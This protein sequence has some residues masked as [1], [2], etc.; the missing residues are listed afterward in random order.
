MKP[1]ILIGIL[2][3]LSIQ[4]QGQYYITSFKKDVAPM[5]LGLG[6]TGIGIILNANADAADLEEINLLNIDDLNFLDRG[7]V[8]SYSSTAHT[9]SDLILY[10]SATLP[11]IT[12]FSNKRKANSGAIALMAIETALINN[13]I[14]TIV[15]S[16]VQRYRPFNYNPR[17][18]DATK[19][20]SSSRKSFISGHVSTTASFAFL[21]ARIITDLHPGMKR[22][23]LVWITAACLPTV[24]G[25]LRIKA[26]KHFLTDVIGGYV[27]G[28]AIG[29]VIPSMHLVKNKNLK[30][31]TTGIS[32]LSL[33][34]EF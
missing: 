12:Y 21:T 27:V 10:S 29:Y 22:K 31:G 24:V 11:F 26:G 18:D 15:K 7:E 5:T 28:A 8:L 4:V 3:L 32:G 30:I 17:V 2:I 34:L 1:H 14:T 23:H 19:L 13:G 25:F 33:S 20:G 6:L 9:I 16:S